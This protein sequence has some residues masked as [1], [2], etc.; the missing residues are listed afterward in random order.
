MSRADLA[1]LQ[2]AA[3][4]P[5]SEWVARISACWRASVEAI[6]EVGRLLT[7]ARSA[8]GHGEWEG[9]CERELPFTPRTAQMLMAIAKDPRLSNPKHV[10][11][12]P[13]AWGTLY[14]L[15]KLDDDQF[16]EKVADGTI[17]PDMQRQ[18][19][20]GEIKRETRTVRERELGE[21]QAA[22][23]EKKYG[24]IVADPEWRFEPW[25]RDTGMDRSA[26]NHYPTSCLE[27]IAARPVF[28][29]AAPDCVLFLWATA[30]MLPHA[31]IVMAAWG[32]DYR[33]NYVWAKDRIGTGYWNRNQHE[34]LL[35]G[36]RGNVPAPAMG[37]QW[38][39]LIEAPVTKHS[40]KPENFLQMIED[41]F[42]TLP[43]IELN[44]RG[45]P[46]Q[47]WDAWGNETVASADQ[48]PAQ[49]VRDV[50]PAPDVP[51]AGAGSSSLDDEVI[52]LP[53]ALN[54]WRTALGVMVT[55]SG[56]ANGQTLVKP[57][58]TELT[59]DSLAK[60]P[61]NALPPR[62][63]RW[64]YDNERRIAATEFEDGNARTER[65]CI[66]CALTK[67][68]VHQPNGIAYREW[69]SAKARDVRFQC[70][71]T[72]PCITET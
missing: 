47:G 64:D 9:M 40:A 36:V 58:L 2:P 63:H 20:T 62:K 32:F 19:I 11:L 21:R 14:E 46:R 67:V 48:P 37:T 41:Y 52:E 30:P 53:G 54:S 7:E 22:M 24:V 42:P 60:L 66:F 33:S 18:T 13:P 16:E 34:H 29:I 25:S 1:K 35:L 8:L 6:L 39:S 72:P 50:E 59:N 15:T 55:E 3:D 38:R 49:A 45:P 17:W 28:T 23:P 44:R 43:K 71:Q 26:D 57:I 65:D 10:S 31:L 61:V 56:D 70:E 12:L 69:I 51:S 5:A 4:A 27:V 68:T